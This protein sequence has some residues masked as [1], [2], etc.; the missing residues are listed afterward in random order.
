MV[1]TFVTFCTD[2]KTPNYKK[3]AQNLD[4]G[5]L[6]KQVLEAKQILDILLALHFI[7]DYFGWEKMP[8][9]NPSNPQKIAKLFLKRAEWVKTTRKRYLDL[10]IRLMEKR[11]KIMEIPKGMKP[12]RITNGDRY[13]IEHEENL[14]TNPLDGRITVWKKGSFRKPPNVYNLCEILL[15]SDKVYTLGF[16]QHPCVRMWV[17]HEDSLKMYINEHLN[18]HL[19]RPKKSGGSRSSSLKPYNLPEISSIVHPW[20]VTCRQV[21]YSHR[22]SLFR[23]EE[24]RSELAWYTHKKS[25]RNIPKVYFSSGYIWTCNL[26]HDQIVSLLTNNP[27]EM[28]NCLDKICAPIGVQTIVIP[29]KICPNIVFVDKKGNK[30]QS[31]Y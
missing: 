23:K 4:N 1:N 9:G 5:R 12:L 11:S 18:E 21:L 31:I 6:W 19:R 25:F 3:C 29:K 2:S 26:T 17:G 14:S 20:W 8:K 7:A 15:P 27:K 10:D 30:I 24:N 22:A 16:S 28:D 13:K